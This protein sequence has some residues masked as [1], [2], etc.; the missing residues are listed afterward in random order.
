MKLDKS[1]FR[2]LIKTA[3]KEEYKKWPIEDGNELDKNETP[4]TEA[5]KVKYKSNDW[6]KINKIAKKKTVMIQTAFGDEFKWEEGSSDGVFGTESN[7]REI[8]LTHDDIDVLFI[9]AKLLKGA[10]KIGKTPQPKDFKGD[11]EKYLDALN[12]HM[13]DVEKSMKEG[14]LSEDFKNN[15]WE[16]Y[17]ADENRREKIVKVA[18]SKRAAVILYNKLIK[19]D[20]YHEVGMR[21]IKEGKITEGISVADTRFV[22]KFVIHILSSGSEMRSAILSKRNAVKYAT[23]NQQDVNSLWNLAG[24]YKGKEIKEGKLNERMDKKKAAI[25]LKQI[26]GN[27]F[28]AMTGAK[29]FA[30]SDKYMSFK[31]GRNSK[32]INFV[33]IAHNSMDTYDMEFGFVSVKGI[34]VKST[35]KGVYADMLGQIFKKN[36]GMNTR[37]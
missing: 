18:K 29:G 6:K 23:K 11:I 4:I 13:K 27:R 24:K 21:V 3:I 17:V 36:T 26:G 1:I 37:L 30:F 35:E 14:K 34:K 10:K 28:I 7:G 8:E 33:R 5:K 25:I 22:G 16:V 2:S 31:I 9:E 15:E 12:K 20:K 19:T 32:G